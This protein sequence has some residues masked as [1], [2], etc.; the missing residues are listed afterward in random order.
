MAHL[1]AYIDESGQRASTTASS[2]HFVMSAVVMRETRRS[3]ATDLLAKLRSDLGRE[4]GQ[5]LHWKKLRSHSSRLHAAQSIGSASCIVITSVIVCKRHISTSLPTEDH[6]YL[7]TLRYLLER[8]SWFGKRHR[9]PV[10]YTL[11]HIVRFKTASLRA[12]EAKLRTMM[13]PDCNIE[14]DWIAGPG[15]IDQTSRIE[16]LQLADLVASATAQ[17]FEPDAHGNTERRYLEALSGRLYRHGTGPNRLT[18]YGMKMHPWNA[19][20]QAAY[21]WVTGL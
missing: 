4:P 10:D 2:D 7:Y 19:S 18:S 11:A 12:Y 8:L 3:E 16:E 17:A 20:S 6:A 14:W 13:P 21:P 5:E 15:R 9:C 1:L